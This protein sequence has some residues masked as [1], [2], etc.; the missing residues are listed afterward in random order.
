VPIEEVRSSLELKM[1][2]SHDRRQ[3]LGNL[4]NECRTKEFDSIASIDEEDE[5]SAQTMDKNNVGRQEV[6]IR[7]NSY[8]N[9][10]L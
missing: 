9:A 6:M 5:Y 4:W 8:N 10:D 3:I 7:E 1:K 2:H